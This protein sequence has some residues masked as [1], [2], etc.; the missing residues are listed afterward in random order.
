MENNYHGI[1]ILLFVL[2]KKALKSKQKPH[3]KMK[4]H[5]PKNDLPAKISYWN[6]C[7]SA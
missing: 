4:C 6:W 7:D 3:V 1:N 5:A 2:L